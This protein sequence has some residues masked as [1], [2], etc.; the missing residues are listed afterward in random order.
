M[1]TI[2]SESTIQPSSSPFLSPS[3]EFSDPG[4]GTQL[5]GITG[6]T[7]VVQDID[8]DHPVLVPEPGTLLGLGLF[9]LA[10]VAGRR[11]KK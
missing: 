1:T 10:G 9:G 3:N 2:G 8:D 6:G 4:G 11:L 7:V 5:R